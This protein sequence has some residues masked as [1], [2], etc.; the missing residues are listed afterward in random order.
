MS[1]RYMLAPNKEIIRALSMPNSP[2][3]STARPPASF[4]LFIRSRSTSSFP[5]VRMTPPSSRT[6][7]I[8]S[9]FAATS[10]STTSGTSST[11]FGFD[12]NKSPNSDLN[13]E[14]GMSASTP[15]RSAAL[16]TGSIGVTTPDPGATS[17]PSST[18]STL[19]SSPMA[20]RT[21]SMFLIASSSRYLEK[22]SALYVGS[23]LMYSLRCAPLP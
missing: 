1:P 17:P 7:K 4:I 5:G 14:P 20:S 8:S 16:R 3:V 10:G 12:L 13:V 15:A 6:S 18:T 22:V 19:A 21:R 9:I 11:F 23:P 2:L